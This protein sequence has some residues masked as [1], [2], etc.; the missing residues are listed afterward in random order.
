M[1]NS[2]LLG[3]IVDLMTLSLITLI[4]CR[5]VIS[6]ADNGCVI[7]TPTVYFLFS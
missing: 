6:W 3:G 1:E 5:H 7:N 2:F 4:F